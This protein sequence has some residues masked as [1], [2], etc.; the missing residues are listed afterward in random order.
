VAEVLVTHEGRAWRDAR[1]AAVDL[2]NRVDLPEPGALAGAYPHELSGGQ[3]QRVAVAAAIAAGPKLLIADEAT[4]A[5]DTVVQAGIVRLIDRLVRETGTALLVITHDLALAARLAPEAAVLDEGRLVEAGPIARLLRQPRHP[6]TRALV[7]GSRL[8][9]ARSRPLPGPT[10]LE[11]EGLAKTFRTRG[12]AVTA[13]D[14]VGLSVAAGE[15]VALVGGS[16]SG[17]TTLARLILRLLRP[18]AGRIAFAGGDLLALEGRAL[19]RMRRRLQMVFQ[20]PL[21]ALNPRATV[22]RLLADPLRVHGLVPRAGRAAAVAALLERVGLPPALAGRR[23]HELSGGQRQR[24]NIARALATRPDLVVLD[25]PVASLDAA[26][27]GRVLDLL[28]G[29]QEETGVAYLF[30][31]HDLAVVRAVAHRVLVADRGRIVEEGPPEAVLADPRSEA[32]R[33]LVAAIPRLPE[34]E[35]IPP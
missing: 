13:V 17:K 4:T 18:D 6:A 30:V 3:R 19:R 2:F 12:R 29:L 20:D 10:L 5:L 15:T 22:A 21:G 34:P 14:G 25:E 24:V 26:A 28:R 35:E 9:P 7:E 8:L 23:P 32:A 33:A 31:S 27:R 16:G 11:A 1:A